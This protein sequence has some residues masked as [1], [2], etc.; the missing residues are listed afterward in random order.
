MKGYV[1]SF[2][3]GLG[4]ERI[5]AMAAYLEATWPAVW[6]APTRRD[7]RGGVYRPYVPD[8][9]TGGHLV[10]SP[11]VAVAAAKAEH[12]VRRLT[13]HSAGHGVDGLARFL[14]RSEAIASS[15]IEGLQT[16]PQQ[17]AL[18]ELAAQETGVSKGFTATAALV[19]NNVTAG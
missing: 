13:A 14:L 1:L 18:A 12:L 8:R 4:R 17:V 3:R 11:D 7:R 2:H 6:D 19:A 10:V 9:L 5:T 15:R 16:S